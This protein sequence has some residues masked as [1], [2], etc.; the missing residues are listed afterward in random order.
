MLSFTEASAGRGGAPVVLHVVQSLRGGGA[1][2]FVRE[3]VPRL[4]HR[5]IDARVMCAYGTTQLT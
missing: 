5:G 1:E 2:A 3:L 4:R